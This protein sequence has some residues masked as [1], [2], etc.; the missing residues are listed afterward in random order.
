MAGRVLHEARMGCV[1]VLVQALGIHF[2]RRSQRPAAQ[3]LDRSWVGAVIKEIVEGSIHPTSIYGN[4]QLRLCRVLSAGTT[5]ND[6][7]NRFVI[8]DRDTIFSSYLDSELRAAEQ[9]GTG[10]FFL[11][12]RTTS[13]VYPFGVRCGANASCSGTANAVPAF[14]EAA[15]IVTS[16]YAR[17]RLSLTSR[18]QGVAPRLRA[19]TVS[20]AIDRQLQS[21]LPFVQTGSHNRGAQRSIATFPSRSVCSP[22][23][24][25]RWVCACCTRGPDRRFKSQVN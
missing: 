16:S 10:T 23:T 13:T 9:L 3:R 21:G 14:M 19:Q 2:Q 6:H 20:G 24:R 5:E 7:R 1:A 11:R 8:H 15:A 18:C 12:I 22:H 17:A 25:V 4:G